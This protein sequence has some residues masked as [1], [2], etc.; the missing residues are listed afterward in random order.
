MAAVVMFHVEQRD[1][2]IPAVMPG[3]F[4]FHVK[5]NR[6][7]STTFHVKQFADFCA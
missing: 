4:L 7:D 2:T 5:Q 6:A 1:Q 3:F